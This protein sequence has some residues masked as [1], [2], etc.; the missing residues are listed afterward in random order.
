ML[1]LFVLFC[2][3]K[4]EFRGTYVFLFYQ[5]LLIFSYPK[6]NIQKFLFNNKFA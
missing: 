5:K 6:K 4:K 1:V 2:M 3:L